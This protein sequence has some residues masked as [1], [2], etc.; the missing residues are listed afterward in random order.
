MK[1]LNL[2]KCQK[3]WREHHKEARRAEQNQ[4]SQQS[5]RTKQKID[6]KD[7][8]AAGQKFLKMTPGEKNTQKGRSKG[9]PLFI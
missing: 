8:T 9:R 2:E 3:T 6:T 4:A 5:E 1:R 7:S